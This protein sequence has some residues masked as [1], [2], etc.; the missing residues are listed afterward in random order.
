MPENPDQETK[1]RTEKIIFAI[2]NHRYLAF[3]LVACIGIVGLAT[4][5]DSIT[6]IRQFFSLTPKLAETV[7]FSEDDF[8][9]EANPRFSFSFLYPKT[10]DRFDPDNGDGNRYVDPVN[11][12]V[13]CSFWGNLAVSSSN[14][15]E[16]VDWALSMAAEEP[17]FEMIANVES[18]RHQVSWMEINGEIQQ[19]REQIEG[20]RVVY[21]SRP[22]GKTT[23]ISMHLFLHTGDREIH[24]L[25]QSPESLFPAYQPLFLALLAEV[26]VLQ[27]AN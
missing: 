10:W 6:S 27:D 14:L 5:T 19:S 13:Q 26:R 9:R 1:S 16:S 21:R 25:C 20:R 24:A 15:E 11:P 7:N 17:D 3:F 23:V 18:G 2:N 4:L 22:E 12:D 8:S